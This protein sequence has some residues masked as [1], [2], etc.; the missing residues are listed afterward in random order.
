MD[1]ALVASVEAELGVQ[2]PAAYVELARLHNGG[3]LART[4]HPV[5]SPTSWAEDHVGVTS[6]FAIGRTADESLCGSL[7]SKFWVDEWGY[8]D[9]GIYFADCPSAGHDMIAL[10]Y[11][12]PGEPRVV[13]VDQEVDY[14]ITN[15][16][17]TFA[18]FITGL[19]DDSGYGNEL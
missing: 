14:R 18:A 13:H 2:L 7:K 10:D 19:V 12:S 17:P 3:Y 5:E 11:R 15:L 16:A 1:H 6:I 9:I 4:S 8:P